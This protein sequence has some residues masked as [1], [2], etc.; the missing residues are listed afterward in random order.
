MS[1][2]NIENEIEMWGMARGI[3]QHGKP[4]G[5]AIKTMEECTELLDAINKGD[6]GAV[7]DA[8][9]D[10][11]VTLLMQCAIQNVTFT[12]CLERAFEVIKDRKGR[13]LESGIFVKE[14]DLFTVPDAQ[15]AIDLTES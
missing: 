13:L 2:T 14:E 6:K 15:Q 8:I 10:I 1:F 3:I 11:G 4:M 12:E 5:Q 7:I 9:G